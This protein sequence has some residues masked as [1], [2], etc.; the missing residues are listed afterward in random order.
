MLFAISVLSHCLKK[1]GT[2]N[3]NE[4][5][6]NGQGA[7]RN[8]FPWHVYLHVVFPSIPSETNPFQNQIQGGGGVWISKK[9]ILTCAHIFYPL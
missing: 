1:C 5:I 4:R 6:F 9:H 3:N 7:S 2:K 8:Q